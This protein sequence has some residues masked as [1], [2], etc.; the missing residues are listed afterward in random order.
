MKYRLNVMYFNRIGL[1]KK[2]ISSKILLSYYSLYQQEN[3]RSS[4]TKPFHNLLEKEYLSSILIH[5]SP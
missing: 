5:F 4:Y 3:K 2:P 1:I